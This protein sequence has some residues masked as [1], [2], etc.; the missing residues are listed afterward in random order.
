MK[1]G[2]CLLKISF[3]NPILR[4]EFRARFRDWRAFL[5]LFA[6]QV[7]FFGAFYWFYG[8]ASAAPDGAAISDLWPRFNGW[9]ALFLLLASPALTAASV[10]RERE[11]KLF[12]ALQLAPI[13]RFSVAAGK[14]GAALLFALLLA[15]CALPLGVFALFL[16]PISPRDLALA[17]AFHALVVVF[18]TAAGLACSAWARARHYAARSVFS[19]F[20]AWLTGTFAAALDSGD[21][22]LPAQSGASDFLRFWGRTNPILGALD[23]ASPSPLE[24]RWP[25]AAI[26]MAAL[27][28]L[29]FWAAVR[30]CG[31]I[32]QTPMRWTKPRATRNSSSK[33]AAKRALYELPL[34]RLFRFDNPI[35]ER[36]IR[37]IFRFP[38][39]P[40]GVVVVQ[41]VIAVPVV[42]LYGVMVFWA[43]TMP[44]SRPTI[45]WGVAMTGLCVSVT[46]CALMGANALARERHENTWTALRLSSLSVREILWG[47]IGAAYGSCVALSLP[48]WP[49]LVACVRPR[50]FAWPEIA[51]NDVILPVQLGA[52][53]LVWLGAMSVSLLLGM[54]VGWRSAKAPSAAGAVLGWQLAIFL[55]GPL[56]LRFFPGSAPLEIL[57]ALTNPFLAILASASLESPLRALESGGPF[58]ALQLAICAV[59]WQLLRRQIEKT[60]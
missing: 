46:A 33:N 39:P 35:L 21:W 40:R 44:Q 48:A 32:F 42:F 37:A 23:L 4:R 56:L 5:A 27:V 14:W 58:F 31:H 22:F 24:S 13:S 29:L 17:G 20:L 15:F 59:L 49:L 55:V 34:A 45:F 1:R 41:S 16:L 54:L 19:L 43:F 47:K 6:V 3:D 53:L 25:V 52:V 38:P 18:G 7:A 26:F 8:A 30:G 51:P 28:P 9:L 2:D 11:E 60:V 50:G 57:G 12:E 10:A 36:E